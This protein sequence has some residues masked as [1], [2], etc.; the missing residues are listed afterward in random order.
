MNNSKVK[1]AVRVRPLNQREEGLNSECVARVSGNQITLLP[2]ISCKEKARKEP[3]IFTYDNCFW[4]EGRHETG[5]EDV[6]KHLGD[7]ALENI[8]LGFN[9]CIFAYGQTG[10]GKTFSMMGTHDQPGIVPRICSALF[11]KESN[12]LDTIRIEASYFE[13]YNEEVR[14]LLRS[15][16]K[17]GKLRVRQDQLLGPYVEELS[18]HAVQS[19]EEIKLLLDQGNKQRAIA[20]TKMNEQSSRSH[21]ILTLTVTQTCNDHKSGAS[22]E[23][24]SKVSLVDLAGSE[25]SYK[26]GA[27]G[28]QLKECCNINK[29]LL[30][31]G[32]V[33]NSLAEISENKRKSQYVRYRDSVLTLLLKNNLG[34]NSKT[35]MLATVSPAADNYQETLSTLR[36]A[37]SAK[38][39]VNQAVVN[40]DVKSKA[41]EELQEEIKRLSEQL[42]T[43]EHVKTEVQKLKSQL[44]EKENLLSDLKTSWEEKLKRTEVATQEWKKNLENMGVILKKQNVTFSNDC[45][46]IQ[47]S[48]SLSIHNIN[49]IIKIGSGPSQDIQISGPD[50]E[51][52]HCVIRK[53]EGEVFLIAVNDSK[54][55]VNG[56]FS[57]TKT[58][59]WHEDKIQIGTN[60][61]VL[62]QPS[63]PKPEYMK[64][65]VS[66]EAEVQTYDELNTENGR[67]P[68]LSEREGWNSNMIENEKSKTKSGFYKATKSSEPT[69]P[70][71][72]DDLNSS[73]NK[74]TSDMFT[75][76]SNGSS[77]PFDIKVNTTGLEYLEIGEGSKVQD[78]MVP[79]SL[80]YGEASSQ[81]SE[82]LRNS[83]CL[84]KT[85]DLEDH[86]TLPSDTTICK[87]CTER[88]A[89]FTWDPKTDVT[90]LLKLLSELSVFEYWT[91]CGCI[92]HLEEDK[93]KSYVDRSSTLFL[94][95]SYSPETP[96]LDLFCLKK[97]LDYSREK[98]GLENIKVVI[99]DVEDIN[100]ERKIT[101]WWMVGDYRDWELLTLSKTEM[102]SLIKHK[103]NPLSAE[104]RMANKLR[105]FYQILQEAA[106][107][108]FKQNLKKVS[109]MYP[110]WATGNF[111]AWSKYKLGI[112]SRSA[113]SDYS[114]ITELLHSDP[115]GVHV[116][117]V[118]HSDFSNDPISTPGTCTFGILYFTKKRGQINE[119]DDKD[120]QL[121]QQ[122]RSRHGKD[123]VI[124]VMDNVEDSSDQEKIRI[125]E[126]YPNIGDLYH[127]LFLFSQQE[128]SSEYKNLIVSSPTTGLCS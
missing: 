70:A 2:P 121:I 73:E 64:A 104:R 113:I 65:N 93:W 61:F 97:F 99:A 112:F 63:R 55:H 128:K 8:W 56:C 79:C 103:I 107:E 6:F 66:S 22:R 20:E 13:I 26:S 57:K 30:T 108:Y 120:V 47:Q 78:S 31:L 29:S 11:N 123:N 72:D 33:I 117:D 53:T 32:L 54:T 87:E 21:S 45:Y 94:Y 81:T 19:Y 125:L 24:V 34:G 50:V 35:I 51:C 111:T 88:L 124:I 59:L 3:H 74:Q 43:T 23:L 48:T 9:V 27:Q 82:I 89:V 101:E 36:Y 38:R 98:H 92:S 12:D 5:Q 7:G 115:F 71:S 16:E 77:Q 17:Q 37:E 75:Q 46:L 18:C 85:I 67:S 95:H 10:S 58:Q 40:E 105:H 84:Q 83:N 122:Y 25:R 91:V 14:D 127:N 118:R 110:F 42:T 41:I 109:L 4:T 96:L 62:H 39:I 100:S 116:S 15:D 119:I 1:V 76:I 68:I 114:W 49:D 44:E 69:I 90:P 102:R 60:V 106:E 86:S 52:E 126:S 80:Q 28:S